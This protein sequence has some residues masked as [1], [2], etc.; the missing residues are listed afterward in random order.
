MDMEQDGEVRPRSS[1][2]KSQTIPELEVYLYLLV[3]LLLL[4]HGKKE[5][6]CVYV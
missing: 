3:L 2:P 5:Q 4:D 6:V 1:K